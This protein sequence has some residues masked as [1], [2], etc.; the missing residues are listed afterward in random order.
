MKAKI[1]E[2]FD[3]NATKQITIIDDLLNNDLSLSEKMANL[4]NSFSELK[5]MPNGENEL[6]KRLFE[7]LGYSVYFPRKGDN[8]ERFDAILS[9]EEIRAVVEIEI[10]S[11]A[12]LDAPRNLLDDYAVI[13]SR[14]TD[15]NS[16]IV[17][18]VIC[19]DLPNK[20]TDYWNVIFDI[21][22]ILK[23]KIKTI[24]ILALA[25]FYWTNTALDLKNNDFY[26]DSTDS[27]MNSVIALLQKL[28]VSPDKFLGYFSPFK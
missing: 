25:V 21:N 3:N 17:P 10:P 4:N 6:I 9:N 2:S 26:L 27:S 1:Y 28:G 14:K 24:S 16:D 22:S 8:S 20:R 13:K 12:I 18:L 11:T 5:L 15:L 23:I 7:E 19:W